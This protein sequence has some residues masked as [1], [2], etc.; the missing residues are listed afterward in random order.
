VHRLHLLAE[1]IRREFILLRRYWPNQLALAF[2]I[3]LFFLIIIF[4]GSAMSPTGA[5]AGDAIAGT[6]VGVMMWQLSMGCLGVL[7][8]GFYDEAHAGTLE[9]LYLSPAGTVS[10][11]LAR[12]AANFLSSL[13]MMSV[14]CLLAV[15]TTGVRLDLRPLE[16]AVIIPLSV[17]GTYGF[18]FM[19]A[20]LTMRFKRT[21]AVMQLAQFFF[22]IFTG[23]MFPLESV[24]PAVRFFGEL[25]PL[26]AGIRALRQVTIHSA[27]LLELGPQVVWMAGTSL[28]WLLLGVAV[29]KLAERAARQRGSIGAY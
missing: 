23:A 5:L 28:L 2:T 4:T 16:L 12:S 29:F 17:A 8:W 13:L 19:I 26:T 15:V 20:A 10:I 21:N 25:V 11:L 1:E 14:S 22:L 6:L 18:G 24:H 3:Y 7:G 27:G 9:H